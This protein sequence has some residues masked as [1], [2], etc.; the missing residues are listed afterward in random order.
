MMPTLCNS[1]YLGPLVKV[2][3]VSFVPKVHQQ[4]A[5]Q[6]ATKVRPSGNIIAGTV[7]NSH[8]KLKRYIQQ[9][10]PLGLHGNK[11]VQVDIGIGKQIA[12]GCEAAKY[13]S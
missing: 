7:A 9:D 6:C 10:E 11:E 12:K 5:N 4:K 8:T 2:A 13:G 1:Q 3:P